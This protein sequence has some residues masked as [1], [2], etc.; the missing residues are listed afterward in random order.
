MD[1]NRRPKILVI[2]DSELVCAQ[3]QRQLEPHGFEV[4]IATSP[5]GAGLVARDE[6]PDIILVDLN[7]ASLRGERVI[8]SL[9]ARRDAGDTRVLVYSDREVAVLEEAVRESGADGYLAKSGD[10]ERIAERLR[11]VL[12]PRR[13][14]L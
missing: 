11:D 13:A 10:F 4:V 6:A 12:R 8:R 9:K 7:M 14:D 5:I 1:D 3:T 2:D